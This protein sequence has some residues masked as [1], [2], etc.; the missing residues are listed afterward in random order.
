MLTH[1]ATLWALYASAAAPGAPE[2]AR[3]L[4]YFLS[5]ERCTLAVEPRGILNITNE[6]HALSATIS[7]IP[8]SFVC[9]SM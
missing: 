6:Q 2:A 7:F 8:H 4:K 9:S 1:T 5:D 3:H